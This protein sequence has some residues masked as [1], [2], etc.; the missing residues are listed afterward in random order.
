VPKPAL[1]VVKATIAPEREADFN[2]WYNTRRAAEAAQVPGL[3][4]M[5][6]Y[7]PVPVD[8]GVHPGAEPWQYMVVYEFDS[9]ESLRNFAASETL[10][11]MTVDYEARF[12]GAG[13]RA[14]LTYRQV[15][16]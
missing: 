5:R 13:N 12:G 11:A 15:Y 6:R 2:E 10:R 7:V 4:A 1:F 14:R 16:P 8:V 9:E 3:V